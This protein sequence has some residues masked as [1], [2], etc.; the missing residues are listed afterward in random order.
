MDLNLD[1][2]MEFYVLIIL[3]LFVLEM[4]VSS[5]VSSEQQVGLCL[6]VSVPY[7]VVHVMIVGHAIPV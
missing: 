5:R 6:T 7:S 4:E 3:K 1:D 2:N